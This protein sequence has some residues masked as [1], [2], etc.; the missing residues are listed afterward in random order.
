M[1]GLPPE[2]A[3]WVGITV[4][5]LKNNKVL[6]IGNLPGAWPD[7]TRLYLGTFVAFSHAHFDLLFKEI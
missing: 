4:V 7:L 2:C 5:N 3:S 1:T 6:D